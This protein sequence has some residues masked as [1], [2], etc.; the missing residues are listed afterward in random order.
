MPELKAD[1]TVYK[2]LS[3]DM[4]DGLKNI[5][6]QIST[7][8]N[9]ARDKGS[10]GPEALFNEAADQLDE[11]VKTTESAAMSI[12]E[13]VEKQLEQTQES[14]K[15]LEKINNGAGGEQ[16]LQ[17]LMQANNTLAQDLTTVLT[18]LSFQDITGQRIRK[19][20]NA[21]NA[22]ESSVVELYLSSGLV[23]DAAEKEPERDAHELRQDAQ[24]AMQ[25]FRENRKVNS[26]LKGPSS[27]GASQSA[28]DDMLSQLGL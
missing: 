10:T 4:R 20:V 8:S 16:D 1:N 18:T 26:E 17:K 14:A 24:K 7:A 9:T 23:M 12:M 19:V 22:I 28:I 15:L 27:T 6:H 13:I 3:A 21:L 2:Q 5:Y 11:V 25:D